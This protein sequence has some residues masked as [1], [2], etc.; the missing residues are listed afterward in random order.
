MEKRYNPA[1]KLLSD[2]ESLVD[3]FTAEVNCTMDVGEKLQSFEDFQLLYMVRDDVSVATGHLIDMKFKM[4][5]LSKD[6]K[7]ALNEI[8][9]AIDQFNELYLDENK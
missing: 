1:E 2:I 4:A 9:Q 7:S 5:V 8:L 6:M 3:E